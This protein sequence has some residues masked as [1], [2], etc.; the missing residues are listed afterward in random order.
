M[1]PWRED[2][3]HLVPRREFRC[4]GDLR[5]SAA[6]SSSVTCVVDRVEKKQELASKLFESEQEAV[7]LELVQGAKSSQVHKEHD[8]VGTLIV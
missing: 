2:G 6:V 8:L 7:G 3:A 4:R 1:G 5:S